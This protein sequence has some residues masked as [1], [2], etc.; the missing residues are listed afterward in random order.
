M[1]TP[2]SIIIVLLTLTF[3]AKFIGYETQPILNISTIILTLLLERQLFDVKIRQR[4]CYL[5]KTVGTIF[6]PSP[7]V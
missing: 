4:I 1:L 5:A 2:T 6:V 3:L 7:F